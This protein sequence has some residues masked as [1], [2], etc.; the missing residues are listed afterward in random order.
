[1][2]TE[3]A[4]RK[5]RYVALE[6]QLEWYRARPDVVRVMPTVDRLIEVE[7]LECVGSDP[8][9]LRHADKGGWAL[10]SLQVALRVLRIRQADPG[11]RRLHGR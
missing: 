10:V 5:A 11:L 3:E 6:R 9:V 2:T 7:K 4:E 1:M 8:W